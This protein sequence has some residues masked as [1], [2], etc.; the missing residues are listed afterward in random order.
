MLK[1]PANYDRDNSPAKLTNI[2]RQAS[3]DL[4]LGV[5]AGICHRALVDNLHRI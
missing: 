1:T 2:A 3:S 4:L 5:S